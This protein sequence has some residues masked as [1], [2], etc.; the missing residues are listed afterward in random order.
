MVQFNSNSYTV[1]EG[2]EVNIT[3]D[4]STSD[5]EFNFTVNLQYVNGSAVGESFC[6]H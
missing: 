3:L 4:T 2:N 6:V 1:T 5:Y